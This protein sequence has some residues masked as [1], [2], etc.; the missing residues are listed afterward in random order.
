[1]N[2]EPDRRFY[3]KEF[4]AISHAISTYEDLNTLVRH[5]TEGTA[6]T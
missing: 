6:R 2:K 3:L 4:K 5:L 1:M